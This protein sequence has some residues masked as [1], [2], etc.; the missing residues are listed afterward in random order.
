MSAPANKTITY[1]AYGSNMLLRR[2]RVKNRAPSAIAVCT[3]YVEGRR[4]D[5]NKRSVD[6]S[7]KC[8]IE[9]TGD[10][11]DRAWGVIFRINATDKPAL[12][13]V[14]GL[15]QGYTEREVRVVTP[16]GGV[17]ALTYTALMKA[18][19]LRPYHWYK[20]FVVAGATEH[21]LPDDYIAWLRT[22]EST[23]DPDTGRRRFNE[24][25]LPCR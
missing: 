6:G 5:F 23:A 25:L 2:L 20:A 22:F 1:F 14:E 7:G 9:A 4:L 17:T 11:H 13:R 18:P 15:G 10:P 8:D 3:G 24:A 12:D 21:S 19:D 16:D